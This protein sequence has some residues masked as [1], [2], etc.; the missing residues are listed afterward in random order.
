MSYYL[1]TAPLRDFLEARRD[2]GPRIATNAETGSVYDLAAR[3]ARRLGLEPHGVRRQLMRI[4]ERRDGLPVLQQI[5]LDNAETI[6]IGLGV[7]GFTIWP[8]DWIAVNAHVA[9]IRTKEDAA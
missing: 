7:N 3:I 2:S 5:T 6:C 1:P 4:L 9:R 8:D